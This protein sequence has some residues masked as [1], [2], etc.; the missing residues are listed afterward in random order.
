[1]FESLKAR[2]KSIVYFHPKIT[3]SSIKSK[4]SAKGFWE[5]P[6]S[7]LRHVTYKPGNK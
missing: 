4:F 5:K 3:K 2:I 1:M 7:S 6:K